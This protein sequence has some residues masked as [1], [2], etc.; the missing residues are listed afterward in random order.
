[1]KGNDLWMTGG[2]SWEFVEA[3]NTERA[4]PHNTSETLALDNLQSG[5]TVPGPDL[6]MP[7]SEHC[8]LEVNS[9]LTIAL[10]GNINIDGELTDKSWIFHH[11]REDVEWLQGA[12]LRFALN[13]A[14]C[15][16]IKDGETLDN[17]VVVTQ[18]FTQ[19]GININEYGSSLEMWLLDSS[20]GNWIEGPHMPLSPESGGISRSS[21]IVTPDKL[22]LLLV[23]GEVGRTSIFRYCCTN[24]DCTWTLLEQELKYGRYSAVTMWIPDFMTNCTQS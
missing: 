4:V 11:D 21:S 20:P 5:E 6:P 16:V 12:N 3:L 7:L 23:G 14:N 9:S 8:L 15:G 22:G 10:G 24:M 13:R 18:F 1:M 19:S 17:I 2:N